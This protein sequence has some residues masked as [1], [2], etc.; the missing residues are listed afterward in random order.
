MKVIFDILKMLS[1]E[2]FNIISMLFKSQYWQEYK[3]T[4]NPVFL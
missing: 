1:L 4:R 2:I 3:I